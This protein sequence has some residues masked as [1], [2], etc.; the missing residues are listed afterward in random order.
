MNTITRLLVF[1]ISLFFILI[2]CSDAMT[3]AENKNAHNLYSEIGIASQVSL[4]NQEHKIRDRYEMPILAN[5]PNYRLE[6]NPDNT[7]PWMPQSELKNPLVFQQHMIR[8]S[9]QSSHPV[10]LFTWNRGTYYDFNG[11]PVKPSHATHIRNSFQVDIK[12]TRLDGRPIPTAMNIGMSVIISR[13]D[14]DEMISDKVKVRFDPGEFI[15]IPFDF[16]GEAA[17][18]RIQVGKVVCETKVSY[19]DASTGKIHEMKLDPLIV[20]V[21]EDH[22][23]GYKQAM[24]NYKL[25]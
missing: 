10:D 4:R 12:R 11:K 24:K 20:N 2:M 14:V 13:P 23:N 22:V 9:N 16:L 8:V 3:N 6:L 7:K 18:S 1:T 25:K 5:D 21:T 17:T 15:E 19:V